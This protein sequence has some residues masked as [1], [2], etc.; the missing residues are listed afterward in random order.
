MNE[1]EKI[2]YKQNS[3]INQNDF[4]C[5]SLLKKIDDK[6]DEHEIEGEELDEIQR[7]HRR[8]CS[9]DEKVVDQMPI[10]I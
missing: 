10:N 1:I 9:T 6:F 3:M 2:E 8:M 4:T 5:L 7:K